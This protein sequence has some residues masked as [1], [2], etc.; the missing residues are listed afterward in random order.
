MSVKKNIVG[1]IAS[2][3]FFWII[4]S[5]FI[6]ATENVNVYDGQLGYS[7]SNSSTEFKIWSSSASKIEVVVEGNVNKVQAL[8]K[9]EATNVWIAFV[10]GDLSGCEYSYNIYYADGTSYS[11]V[12]DPYGKY[13]NGEENKNR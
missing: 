7:Y 1:L 9:D 2:V 5:N 4:N 3:L 6:G 11:N 10:G 12:L 13:L 8:E